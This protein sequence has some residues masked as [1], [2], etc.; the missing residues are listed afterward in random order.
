M[1]A[2]NNSLGL[3]PDR[4]LRISRILHR[5]AYVRKEYG[6]YFRKLCGSEA[7]YESLTAWFML[8]FMD[9]SVVCGEKIT[10]L[11]IRGQSCLL[12]YLRYAMCRSLDLMEAAYT[13]DLYLVSLWNGYEDYNEN[14]ETGESFDLEDKYYSKLSAMY[15]GTY[16]SFQEDVSLMWIQYDSVFGF[17][18]GQGRGWHLSMPRKFHALL[19]ETVGLNCEAFASPVNV[20]S[21]QYFSLFPQDVVFGSIGNFFDS[22]LTGSVNQFIKLFPQT[23]K[24]CIEVNPPFEPILIQ[25]VLSIVDNLLHADTNKI[26]IIFVLILPG[27]A[28]VSSVHVK[29]IFELQKG[30]HEYA[31]GWPYNTPMG[32]KRII[33]ND[34][35]SQIVFVSNQPV[36]IPVDLGQKI[37]DA[38]AS[39][40]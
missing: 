33:W 34:T 18:K 9:I 21:A 26:Q 11:P 19:V 1:T 37:L 8:Q 13:L 15:I 10:H 5:V 31:I 7:P 24:I 28:Q 32:Q 38:W 12:R 20:Q 39:E 16:D 36:E 23:D 22:N 17:G 4:K 30:S 35:N 2:A 6:K 27:W 29:H 40:T 14:M 3:L 25:K